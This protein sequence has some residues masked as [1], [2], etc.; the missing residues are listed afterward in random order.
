MPSENLLVKP[1][2]NYIKPTNSKQWLTKYPNLMKEQIPERAEQ[3]YVSGITYVKSR[4]RAH[5]LSLV[6]D[7]YSRKKEVIN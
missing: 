2:K 7:A 4:E 6:T 5:Y 3:F 1:K